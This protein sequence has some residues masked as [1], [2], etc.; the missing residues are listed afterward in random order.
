MA[1]TRTA[2]VVIAALA[3]G[4]A[5]A[6][7]LDPYGQPQPQPQPPPKPPQPPPPPPPEPAP[8]NPYGT[9]DPVLAEQ[10]AE[11]LVARAEQ[12]L[13]AKDYADAKQLAVEALVES[14][15]GTAAE[16]AKYVIKMAN[17]QLGIKEPGEATPPGPVEPP[18]QQPPPVEHPP[19][20]I[21]PIAGDGKY[22]AMVHGGLYGGI[23]GAAIGGFFD[24][25]HTAAG[26]VPTGI[27]LGVGGAL[28][29]PWLARKLKFTEAQVRTAGSAAVWGGVIGGAFT[30][31][32]QGEGMGHAT[33]RGA[34]VGGAIGATVGMFAGGLYA[35]K[36][37]LTRGDVAL[38]DTMAGIGAVGGITIGL[39]MQPAQN[40]AY[41]LN[42]GFGAA[43]GVITGLVA[44]PKTNTTPRRMLRVAG[45]A[46]A[47]GAL[48]MLIFAGGHSPGIQQAV[49]G[50]S[51]VGLVAGAWVGFYLTRK[52]D[53]GLDIK[54]CRRDAAPPPPAIV[55]RDASGAWSIGSL[56]VVPLSPQLSPQRGL[57]VPL[58][59]G[60]F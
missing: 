60:R 36:D 10:I 32:G 27:A 29:A 17:L 25:N 54:D 31:A 6:Q 45:L 19:D 15:R 41:A 24:R 12:L 11:Q 35:T 14:P 16:H 40:E 52:M 30:V 59:G 3:C 22:P 20:V 21:A 58:L 8:Q 46:A 38:V 44:A 7:P 5:S 42:A 48:P 23:V 55:G 18:P 2:I 57:A 28:G 50:L 13:D 53:V 51:T 49:G 56:A 4:R 1:V 26:A 43:A 34:M 9:S 39:L 33:P 37:T 47:G